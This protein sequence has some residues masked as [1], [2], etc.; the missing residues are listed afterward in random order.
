MHDIAFAVTYSNS[1]SK[2]LQV[3]QLL[4]DCELLERIVADSFYF[5]K[6]TG[7]KRIKK[8]TV[9][10]RPPGRGRGAGSS[11]SGCVRGPG[12][13]GGGGLGGRWVVCGRAGRWRVRR[14]PAVD[15]SRSVLCASPFWNFACLSGLARLF[16]TRSV[17]GY[18]ILPLS[19]RGDQPPTRCWGFGLWTSHG[20][21]CQK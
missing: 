17:R 14:L 1:R 3:M 18:S 7:G 19:R 12:G 13:A 4:M 21:R 10:P 5:H 8:P 15:F 6:N 11:A 20:C 2:K 9:Q 16:G